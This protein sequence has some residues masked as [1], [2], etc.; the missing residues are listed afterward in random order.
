MAQNGNLPRKALARVPGGQLLRKDA[1]RAYRALDNYLRHT[2]RGELVNSG[3]G[4]CYRRLGSPGDLARGGEFTQ[5]AAWERYEQGGNLAAAPGTSNHGLGLAVDFV[6]IDAVAAHGAA[7][8]WRKTEAFGEPWHYCFVPGRY[9]LVR[10]WAGAR[11]GDTLTPGSRGPGLVAAKK[12]LAR[13]GFWKWPLKSKGYSR[14]FGR[15]VR[16]FQRSRD[17]EPDGVVGPKTW[18]KL[19][20]QARP[21]NRTKGRT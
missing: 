15:Q 17:L 3:D 14:R 8:G 2:G 18:I 19:R 16:A 7:F 21:A 6:S 9:A 20:A 10:R 11:K 1:A 5:W 4:S 12:L 13:H